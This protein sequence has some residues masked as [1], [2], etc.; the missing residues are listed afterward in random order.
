MGVRDNQGCI[1]TRDADKLVNIVTL[2]KGVWYLVQGNRDRNERYSKK[3][4]RW[5]EGTLKNIGRDNITEEV[6]L[7]KIMRNKKVLSFTVYSTI[8]SNRNNYFQSIYE[9]SD[10]KRLKKRKLHR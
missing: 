7:H 5:A 4:V 6:L 2:G 1:I 9:E 8:H 10:I 3:S